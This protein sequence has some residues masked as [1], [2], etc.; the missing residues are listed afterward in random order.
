MR[1]R[2]I[3]HGLSTRGATMVIEGFMPLHH[4]GLGPR[5]F[6]ERE[7]LGGFLTDCT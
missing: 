4:R 5:M 7:G 3:S 1:K 6:G 2:L